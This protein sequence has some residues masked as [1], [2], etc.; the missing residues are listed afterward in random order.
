MSDVLPCHAKMKDGS[1]C[2][3][4]WTTCPL[5]GPQVPKNERAPSA[6]VE[7]APSFL[8]GLSR[9]AEGFAARLSMLEV[10]HEEVR[11]WTTYAARI[12]S[13]RGQPM[14]PVPFRIGVSYAPRN[15]TATGTWRVYFH[16]LNPD[17]LPWCVAPDAGGWE[18][19]VAVVDIQVPSSAVYRPKT[20][21]DDEDGRP[22]AWIAATGTL[23]VSADGRATIRGSERAA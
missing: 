1:L 12:L 22:S 20:T 21:P 3:R 11:R 7:S 9:M 5:H 16:R 15:I 6:G 2:Q 23:T 17:G 10:Q 14:E 13:E 4:G 19:A 8:D 18:I